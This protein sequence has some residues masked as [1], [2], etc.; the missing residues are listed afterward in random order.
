MRAW[1]G[2]R[3]GAGQSASRTGPEGWERMAYTFFIFIAHLCVYYSLFLTKGL[4]LG[5]GTGV[6]VVAE[7]QAWRPTVWGDLG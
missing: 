2:G 6:A 4:A 7:G 5:L 1:S 3:G